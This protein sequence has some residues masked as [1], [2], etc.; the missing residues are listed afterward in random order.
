VLPSHSSKLHAR[1]SATSDTVYGGDPDL[2]AIIASYFLGLGPTELSAARWRDS[3]DVEPLVASADMVPFLFPADLP[4]FVVVG[5]HTAS[6]GEALAYDLQALGRA[7][8]VGSPTLGAAHRIKQFQ[9]G[10]LVATIPC[11]LVTNP[12]TGTDWEASGVRPDVE[13]STDDALNRAIELASAAAN[14]ETKASTRAISG[15]FRTTLTAS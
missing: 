12:I 4:L 15:V 1:S 3:G 8:V 9:V 6:G 14:P 13:A 2:I 5:S 7:V 10:P 11:G